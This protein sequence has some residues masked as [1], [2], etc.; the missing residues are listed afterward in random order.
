MPDGVFVKTYV[1]LPPFDEREILRYAGVRGE[2]DGNVLALL[3]ECLRECEGAFSFRAC[4]LEVP[5]TAEL[6]G[7]SKGLKKNLCGCE[8]ATLFAAT[9]GLGIDRLIAKYANV[10][11]AKALLFQAIGAE[12]IE[13]LCDRLCGELA[14]EKAKAGLYPRPRFSPGYGDFPLERQR[15][16][17]GLLD[18]PR[19]IGLTLT[20]SLL[21]S[22]TK[23]VTAV[24]GWS[25]LPK[26]S[27]RGCASCN[28]K[29]CDFK[30]YER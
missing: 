28:K 4:Y 25:E 19:K 24:V 1:G 13:A 23:S 2:A 18:C 16:F 17:F 6:L 29:D 30:E 26:S 10:S 27:A 20:D 5:V 11:P 22:P 3:G 9:V 15:E 12:R 8:R 21:M 7:E 14:A